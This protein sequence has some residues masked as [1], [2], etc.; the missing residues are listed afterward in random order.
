[1]KPTKK[2]ICLIAVLWIIAL[3]PGLSVGKPVILKLATLAPEGS[4]WMKTFD[5]VNLELES[6][7]EGAV[8]MRAYPGGVMG[9]DQ[10]VLRKMRINQIHM[11][12]ITGLGLGTICNEVI[13]L[14]S[15]FLFQS[16]DEVDHVLA[17]VTGRLEKVLREK[18]FIL[19]GWTEIGFVYMM[20]NKPIATLDDLQGA[21]VWMPEGDPVSQAVFQKIGVSPVPLGIA[22]VLLALQTRL[23]DVVY[24]PPLGAIALQWHTKVNRLCA[25]RRCGDG[26][27]L[28]TGSREFKD[29]SQGSIQQECGSSQCADAKTERRGPGSDGPGGDRVGHDGTPG[30][31]PHR[32]NRRGGES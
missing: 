5:E 7:T 20:S 16:Y 19:L 17:L 23:V 15:P 24:G 4:P 14:G 28:P 3:L 27:G 11:A 32:G 10:A 13:A 9:D 31:D 22:D 26:E 18:G 21:K 12:G 2:L 29:G 30:V 1:M 8:K 6:R 25:G